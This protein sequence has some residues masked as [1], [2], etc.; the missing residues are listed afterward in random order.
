MT[1]TLTASSSTREPD[2]SAGPLI[3]EIEPA[4]LKRRLDDRTAIVIDVRE[5]DEFTAERIEGALSRPLSTFNPANIEYPDGQTVVLSCRSGN[6][7]T[8]AAQR[9]IDAGRE[10]V[11]HLKGGLKAWTAAGLPVKKLAKA[12]I[13]IMRQVQITAGSM[14]FVGTILGA[15]VSPWFLVIPGFIGAGLVFAGLSGTCG[16]ATMLSYMPWNKIYRGTSSC[17][18]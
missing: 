18:T 8:E 14:A 2:Q 17:S 7:S 5:L 13:S 12:P 16:M 11:C 15:F 10:K 1:S 6:R 9:L 3:H 4:D